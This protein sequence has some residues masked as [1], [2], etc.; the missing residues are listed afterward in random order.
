MIWI[1]INSKLKINETSSP[2][3]ITSHLVSLDVSFIFD[4]DLNYN[5][6]SNLMRVQ[7]KITYN[8]YI[9][10]QESVVFVMITTA[11]VS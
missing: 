9:C 5:N 4:F 3:D 10:G 6:C 7:S 11:V 2:F 8:I 1:K